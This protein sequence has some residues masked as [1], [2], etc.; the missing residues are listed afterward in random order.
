[1]AMRSLLEDR[2][3]NIWFGTQGGGVYRYS[4]ERFITYQVL[5]GLKSNSIWSVLEDS[6]GNYWY[7]TAGGVSQFRYPEGIS[8]DPIIQPEIAGLPDL[9][10]L[11]MLEDSKGNI[12]FA[13]ASGLFKYDGNRATEIDGEQLAFSYIRSLSEDTEGNIY[14]GTTRGVNKID[15][16]GNIQHLRVDDTLYTANVYQLFVDR[17][18]NLW[19]GTKTDGLHRI[20][21]GKMARFKGTE[22]LQTIYCITQDMNGN[23]WFSAEDAGLFMIPKYSDP[24]DGELEHY[25]TA[26]GLSS[27]NIYIVQIDDASNV[28]TGTS[29]GVD[30]LDQQTGMIRSY[31]KREGFLGMETNLNAAW[32]DSKGKIWFGTV[33]GVV[34]YDASYDVLSDIT[35]L[36]TMC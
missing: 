28:W 2:E 19:V 12:W 16:T 30:K 23:I 29:K 15:A 27:S 26:Q 3:G 36:R 9:T 35:M 10:T 18:D 1:M 21:E 8:N 33:N 4:G 20:I 14:V 25:T 6:K 32:K 5:D 22:D 34:R 24:E 13:T 7:G 11:D 31:G 17:S